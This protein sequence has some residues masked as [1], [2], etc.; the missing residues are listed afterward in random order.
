[1]VNTVR[2][3]KQGHYDFTRQIGVK[4]MSEFDRYS[5]MPEK[6]DMLHFIES[7]DFLIKPSVIIEEIVHQGWL[8]ENSPAPNFLNEEIVQ[9][10]LSSIKESPSEFL[11]FV[12]DDSANR[13]QRSIVYAWCEWC[14]YSDELAGTIHAALKP[15]RKLCDLV[16]KNKGDFSDWWCDELKEQKSY[17]SG[18][19]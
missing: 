4:S 3:Q 14:G 15:S 10:V 13:I 6:G 9:S 7:D 19:D 5:D 8:K 11:F 17:L 2:L 18:F 1:M 12:R 16:E